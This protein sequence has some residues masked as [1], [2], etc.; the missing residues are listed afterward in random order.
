MS[1]PVVTLPTAEAGEAA[2]LAGRAVLVIDVLRATTT[3][4]YALE[5][6]A[7]EVWPA[8]DVPAAMKLADGLAHDGV[9]LCGE[10]GGRKI[11]GFDLGNSPLEYTRERVNGRPLVFAS[12][13]GS[14]ALLALR[15]VARAATASLV[16]AQSAAAWV[17]RSLWVSSIRPPLTLLCSG[18]EGAES[19]EDLLG[20][21]A[22][23]YWLE[24]VGVP[25]E[26][27][28]ASLRA[29]ALYRKARGHLLA[30]L[31][32][33]PHGAYLESLGFG[34]DLKIA[35]REN[36]LDVEPLWGDGRLYTMPLGLLWS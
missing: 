10:R 2:D 15:G 30:A 13:N 28:E 8:A 19:R 9:L 7:R 11:P 21:G 25:L 17:L 34:E 4:A 24:R 31:R 12:T 36:A 26:P 3:L 35:A 22:V 27:D 33:C 32:D 16:N 20:A 6:G 1:L 5:H 18:Q 23:L 29:L 14:R